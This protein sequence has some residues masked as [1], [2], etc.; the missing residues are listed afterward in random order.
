MIWSP[1]WRTGS[2][3]S[4][5][6]RHSQLV[7]LHSMCR[8][9]GGKVNEGACSDSLGELVESIFG[10]ISTATFVAMARA[11]SGGS[12]V[13]RGPHELHVGVSGVNVLALDDA[14]FRRSGRIIHALCHAAL[15]VCVVMTTAT[16]SRVRLEWMNEVFGDCP[17]VPRSRR[18]CPP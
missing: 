10:L 6:R 12:R 9:R 3:A 14:A 5:R 4:V 11:T 8:T 17:T 15:E 2:F 7:D 13:C 1:P 16:P 18:A